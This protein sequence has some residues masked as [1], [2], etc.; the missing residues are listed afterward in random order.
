MGVKKTFRRIALAEHPDVNPDDPDADKKFQK[1]IGA[2]NSIMGDELM[3]DELLELRVQATKRY[4]EKMKSELKTGGDIIY[5]GNARLVQAVVQIGFFA[6]VA[7]VGT[8]PQETLTSLLSPP[9]Q[10]GF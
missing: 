2:Y 1:L 7:Y 8:L 5:Q 9:T 10:R 4:Q 3:P 6:L